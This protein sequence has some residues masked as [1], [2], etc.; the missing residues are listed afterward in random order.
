MCG[1]AVTAARIL[2]LLELGEEDPRN[3]TTESTVHMVNSRL[4]E[5]QLV[6]VQTHNIA[7]IIAAC[8]SE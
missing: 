5:G 1:T 8:R 2:Y 6:R 3:L 7:E 4:D